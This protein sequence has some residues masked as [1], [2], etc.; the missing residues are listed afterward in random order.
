ME[1]WKIEKVQELDYELEQAIAEH[2]TDKKKA[3]LKLDII[4]NVR[5]ITTQN[6]GYAPLGCTKFKGHKTKDLNQPNIT[7][8]QQK[9]TLGKTLHR[10]MHYDLDNYR[11]LDVTLSIGLLQLSYTE[12][13][14]LMDKKLAYLTRCIRK[15]A[16]SDNPFYYIGK[17]EG[18]EEDNLMH[19]HIGIFFIVCRLFD[20]GFT[21]L[22][23]EFQKS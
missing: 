19:F 7:I 3:F 21:F 14:K 6:N 20:D 9:R 10:G 13:I 16:T 22:K 12:L 18:N 11:A 23:R 1:Q 2:G 8:Q 5:C 17:Y 15:Y 4:N